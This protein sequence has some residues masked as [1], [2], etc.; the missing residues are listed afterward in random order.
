MTDQ[1]QAHEMSPEEEEQRSKVEA[2]LEA[3]SPLFPAKLRADEIGYLFCCIMYSYG[4]NEEA[5]LE[6][7]ADATAVYLAEDLDEIDERGEETS[8]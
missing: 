7:M 8:Q 4:I 6:L 2:F 1:H 3:A 5:A